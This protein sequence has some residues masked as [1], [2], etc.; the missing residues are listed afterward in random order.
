MFH[1]VTV[2]S[3]SQSS[4]SWKIG[5]SAALVYI[6]IVDESA[7]FNHSLQLSK[8]SWNNLIPAVVA[9]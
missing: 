8:L 1:V 2:F 5:C 6:P 4:I 9:V 3:S 7:N